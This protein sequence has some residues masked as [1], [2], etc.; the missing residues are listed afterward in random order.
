MRYPSRQPIRRQGYGAHFGRGEGSRAR[1]R[2]AH[3][4]RRRPRSQGEQ[5]VRANIP[6]SNG[7]AISEPAQPYGP[8]SRS[9]HSTDLAHC[10][11]ILCQRAFLFGEL[12][13]SLPAQPE[14]VRRLHQCTVSA[15]GPCGDCIGRTP[16]NVA[17][18]LSAG[19]LRS[20]WPRRT[21]TRTWSSSSSPPAP[22]S[23]SKATKGRAVVPTASAARHSTRQLTS[24]Q[25]LCAHLGRVEGP[26]A[27]GRAAH[28]RRRR[29]RRPEQQRVRPLFRVNWL[30]AVRLD[31]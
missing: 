4:R 5:W 11:L 3:R 2:A 29:T 31:S 21:A 27:C 17:T 22:D 10:L 28:R 1:G 23:M 24:R 25:D 8:T 18:E 9:L 6:D 20:S 13:R 16:F 12:V 15:L 14:R 30:C 7:F 26:H 19:T